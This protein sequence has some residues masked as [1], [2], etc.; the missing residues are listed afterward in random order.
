MNPVVHFELPVEDHDR[1]SK[2]Y[3]EAFGWEMNQMG[4]EMGNY[5]VAH[6]SETDDKNMIKEPGR[7]NGG[8]FTKSQDNQVPGV[9]IAVDDIHKAIENVKAAGGTVI[10][11]S[12]GPE[13]IDDIP[14]IGQYVSIRDTEGNRVALLQPNPQM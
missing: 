13:S 2:F 5:T 8:F 6:T 9:V 14:G 1:A 4:P 10:G 3:T 7:I 12:K 11:A